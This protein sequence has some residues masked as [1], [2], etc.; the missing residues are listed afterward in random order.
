MYITTMVN[1]LSRTG[2]ELCVLC[3][4]D[5]PLP[6]LQENVE[7]YWLSVE[8]QLRNSCLAYP[9]CLS[10]SLKFDQSILALCLVNLDKRKSLT[11]LS[12]SSSSQSRTTLLTAG[13]A[14]M[15]VNMPIAKL[16]YCH[17]FNNIIITLADTLE[18]LERNTFSHAVK[19]C[20]MV[21]FGLSSITPVL[22][23][24]GFQGEMDTHKRHIYLTRF[25]KTTVGNL[26]P[27]SSESS[28][29]DEC[30]CLGS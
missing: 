3:D 21:W 4:S 25:Y 28:D 1:V 23:L 7:A 15:N 18:L 6:V 8:H 10:L 27:V 17:S 2:V 5:P 11:C 22:A 19:A 26:L 20:P 29:Q 24:T 9:R 12:P 16:V 14:K 13:E 30:K